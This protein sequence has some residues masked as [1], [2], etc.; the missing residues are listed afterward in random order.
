MRL[1]RSV[2]RFFRKNGADLYLGLESVNINHDELP[3]NIDR[4][5]NEH[6]KSNARDCRICV[7]LLS[8]QA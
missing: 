2:S 7:K 3:P 4:F 5:L 1:K 8:V 6:P